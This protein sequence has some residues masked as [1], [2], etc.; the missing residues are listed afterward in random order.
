[1]DSIISFLQEAPTFYTEEN[2]SYD[3]DIREL[4]QKI[5][6]NILLVFARLV[7]NKESSIEYISLAEHAR[8]LYDKYLFTIPILMDLC[9]QYGHDNKNTTE[10]I[11]NTVF[12]LQSLYQEDLEKAVTF[13]TQVKYYKDKFNNKMLIY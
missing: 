12:K 1:M 2:F 13:I 8:L 11:V 7:T 5:R 9:Q 6:Q 10:K 4:F 3:N